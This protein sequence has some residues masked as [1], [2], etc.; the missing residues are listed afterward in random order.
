MGLPV[1]H[2]DRYGGYLS[3]YLLILLYLFFFF[4]SARR[5]GWAILLG[6]EILLLLTTFTI[7]ARAHC[8]CLPYLVTVRF[9]TVNRLKFFGWIMVLVG[10]QKS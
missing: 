2:N 1:Q 5:F 9:I 10:G 4:V 7:S 3:C 6:E 8:I